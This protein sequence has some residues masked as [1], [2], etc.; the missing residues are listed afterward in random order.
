[1]TRNHRRWATGAVFAASTL[2][3]LLAHGHALLLAGSA[4]VLVIIQA[5]SDLPWAA[6]LPAAPI[7]RRLVRVAV[8]LL[9]LVALGPPSLTLSLLPCLVAVV[10]GGV[11]LLWE[12]RNIWMSLSA[13]YLALHP[14]S[15]VDRWRDTFSFAI[16]GAVQEYLYRW[17]VLIPV[18]AWG[19]PLA[20]A[21][22]TALFV[23]EHLLHGR[24]RRWDHHDV[25]V[26]T[27]LGITGGVLVCWSGSLLPAIIGHTLYNAPNLLFTLRRPR[28]ARPSLV[29]SRSGA[30]S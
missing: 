11:P 26:Q 27:L 24:P 17:V 30:A 3:V 4:V 2:C 15:L 23:L 12:F 18:L 10:T 28:M 20:V 16:G 13:E 21:V 25:A 1:M 9:P 22:G 6:R 19:A 14:T 7:V 29:P 8:Y 5:R